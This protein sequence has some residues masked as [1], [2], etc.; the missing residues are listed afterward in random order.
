MSTT[1]IATLAFID[2]G[3]GDNAGAVVRVVDK[4]VALGFWIEHNGDLDI[5]MDGEAATRLAAALIDAAARS[6][7]TGDPS[8]T[9]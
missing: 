2:R 9:S 6:K 1:E 8:R 5:A 3:S 4:I 7:E